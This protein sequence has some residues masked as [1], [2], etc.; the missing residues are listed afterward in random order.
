MKKSR[1]I[2][3]GIHHDIEYYDPGF[4]Q[5]QTELMKLR[6]TLKKNQTAAKRKD[7]NANE[8]KMTDLSMFS[9]EKAELNQSKRS[10]KGALNQ[11]Q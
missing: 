7:P 1:F 8:T 11:T 4:K 5:K 6:Q 2:E 9:K 10:L 3:D